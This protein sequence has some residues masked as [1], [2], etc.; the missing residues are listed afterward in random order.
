MEPF[1]KQKRKTTDA[2][3][4]FGTMSTLAIIGFV[5]WTL[6]SGVVYAALVAGSRADDLWGYDDLSSRRS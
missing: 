2:H 3:G 4:R 6:V 5:I 1:G